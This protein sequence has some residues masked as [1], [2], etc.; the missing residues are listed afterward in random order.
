M[1]IWAAGISAAVAVGT[2]AYSANQNKK[3]AQQ[4]QANLSGLPGGEQLMGMMPGF[5]PYQPIDIFGTA[6][7]AAAMNA[8]KGTQLAM[9]MASRVNRRATRD[10]ERAL[11]TLFGG[12]TA[13]ADQRNATNEA[14][15][16][17]LSGAVSGSTQR[18]LAR[19]ALATGADMGSGAAG[20]LY[21]GYLGQTQEQIVGQGVDA[22]RSLY[23]MYRQAVPLVSGADML[24]YTTMQPGQ[25]VQSALWNELNR[26]NSEAQL[27]G[28]QMQGLQ[29][30]YGGDVN[31]M[32][33]SNAIARNQTD[34]N[35]AM[36]NA[37]QSAA[38]TLTGA[39]TA[40]RAAN[41]R[42]QVTS[43]VAFSRNGTAYNASTGYAIPKV[44]AL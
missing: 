16:Q 39:Y 38:G 32:T 27:A 42:A 8:G 43:P 24:P 11:M 30:A 14:V 29:L 5:E 9:N 18:S 1:S 22:Y 13:F 20:D 37:V 28:L 15:E 34:A 23:S 31:Q 33:G 2:T 44:Q 19:H 6:A 25:A 35:I 17:W 12:G 36:A 10:V 7:Q 4:Q 3:L 26:A 41:N 40:N 21:A